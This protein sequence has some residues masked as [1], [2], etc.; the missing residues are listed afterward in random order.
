M[1]NPVLLIP[2]YGVKYESAEQM[3]ADWEAGKDFRFWRGVPT[4]CSIRD[5][6]KLSYL[7]STITIAD[8]LTKVQISVKPISK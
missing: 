5:L 2:A 4:Y 3:R 7:T 1:L 8:L 6:E